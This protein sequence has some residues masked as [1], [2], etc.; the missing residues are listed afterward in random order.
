MGKL[1]SV[2]AP[3]ALSYFAPGLGSAIG[4]GLLGA[5]AAGSATLGNALLGAGLGAATGGGLKGAALGALSGGIGANIGS[6]PGTAGSLDSLGRETILGGG[7]EGILGSIGRTTGLS[8]GDLPS[9]GGLTGGSGGGSSTFSN[10]AKIAGGISDDSALK[11]AQKQLLAGNQQ[12]LANISSFDPSGLTK[13]PGYEFQR[14]Q[15]EQGLNRALGATGN[16]FSGRALQAASQYNQ[17]YANNAFN[18]YYQR[19][20]DRI[21]KQNELY[22]GSANTRATGTTQRSNNLN[23]L[24]AGF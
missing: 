2:A 1:L 14:A 15:G 11:K 22:G 9:L 10:L 16:V 17:D 12:Q 8:V 23:E 5:G 3:L 6:L 19:E 18:D 24:L 13:D 21:A 20:M 7:G 4:G